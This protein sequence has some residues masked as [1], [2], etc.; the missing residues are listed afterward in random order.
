MIQMKLKKRKEK[1]APF[2]EDPGLSKVIQDL[3][4]EYF[5]I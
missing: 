5:K 3:S 4:L 2:T 1:K